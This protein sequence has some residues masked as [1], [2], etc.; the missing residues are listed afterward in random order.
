MA[1]RM[2]GPERMRAVRDAVGDAAAV[3]ISGPQIRDVMGWTIAEAN[4]ARAVL[5]GWV[6]AREEGP[7]TP[8]AAAS[9]VL[10]DRLAQV[11]PEPPPEPAGAYEVSE[12]PDEDEPIESLVQRRVDAFH[13]SCRRAE[14]A[15]PRT[16]T[17]R[18]DLPI[19]IAHV[20][21]PH[22]DDDGCDWPTLLRHVEAIGAA[23]GM[24]AGNVG[25]VTNSWVGR[26]MR[27]YAHQSTT[28]AEEV[29]LGQWYFGALDHLYVV[30]GN[31][32]DWHPDAFKRMV[33]GA[34]IDVL[35]KHEARIAIKFPNGAET[36][37][38]VRHT[39][40][41]NSMYNPTH[42][43]KR[44]SWRDPWADVYVSGHHHEWASTRQERADGRPVTFIKAR[45]YKMHDS[46]ASLLQFADGQHGH[47]AVTIIDPH[48]PPVERVQV[49]LDVDEAC[50]R[51]AWLRKRRAA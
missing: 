6:A 18:D 37:L 46:Y 51:L 48:A 19:G 35:A 39:Y 27:L 8:P 41:G 47:T 34:R 16:V 28:H 31:H 10:A 22:L 12:V 50:E 45:G 40:K 23:D 11:T 44:E 42:G 7:T 15:G 24:Y 4:K 2:T 38:S 32:D 29:R 25:D 33:D 3:D 5:D 43:H 1:R 21:D 26:L 9:S 17:M 20:G 13:R 30:P 14:M 36:R 49:V